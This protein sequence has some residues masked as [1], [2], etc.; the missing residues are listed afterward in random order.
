MSFTISAFVT[1]VRIGRFI[2]GFH[3]LFSAARGVAV[4]AAAFAVS[5]VAAGVKRAAASK[6]WPLPPR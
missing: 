3:S 2:S 4:P 1:A 6:R 5:A